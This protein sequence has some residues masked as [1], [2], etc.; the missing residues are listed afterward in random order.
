[1]TEDMYVCTL[2]KMPG[3]IKG[4][5]SERKYYIKILTRVVYTVEIAPLS[6][7]SHKLVV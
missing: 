2:H 6:H 4:D 7:D 5:Q 3:Q 1:M